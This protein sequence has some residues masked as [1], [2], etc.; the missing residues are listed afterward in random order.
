MSASGDR[1]RD[2]ELQP[3]AVVWSGDFVHAGAEPGQW[4]VIVDDS[5]APVAAAA[6][7]RPPGSSLVVA[8]ADLP[9]DAALESP[10]FD[11]LDPDTGVVL[12][13]GKQI[14]GVW[15]GVSLTR[16]LLQGSTRGLISGSSLPS[17]P[18]HI[19][20]LV[21]ACAHVESGVT[22][23]TTNRFQRRPSVM[24]P[25]PNANRLSPHKFA[26]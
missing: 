16:A 7:G 11:D 5:G 14:V 12:V 26:W 13:E 2:Q 20:L 24:P 10:A 4:V 8:D 6:P 23:G 17:Y 18:E 21:R 22:C 19:P 1:L 9:A 25:C 3:F 15:A